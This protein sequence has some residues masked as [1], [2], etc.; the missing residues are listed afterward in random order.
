MTTPWRAHAKIDIAQRVSFLRQ[1]RPGA[2]DG[3]YDHMKTPTP[4]DIEAGALREGGAP[5]LFSRE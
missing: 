5:N 1:T 3:E 2:K 4:G